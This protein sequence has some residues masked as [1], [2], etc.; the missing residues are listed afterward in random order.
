MNLKPKTLYDLTQAQKQINALL[1]LSQGEIDP[2]LESF[3]G[4]IDVETADKVQGYY[5]FITYAKMHVE[6][7][8]NEYKRLRRIADTFQR[9]VDLTLSSIKEHMQVLGL[10][11]AN[12]NDVRFKLASCRPRLSID[13][14][15]LPDEW[16]IAITT[17][18]PDRQRIEDAVLSGVEIPGAKLEGGF[19]LRSYSKKV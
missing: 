4:I 8:K 17:W 16:K 6:H 11:E 10:K 5:G 2:D 19:S 13:E 3:M 15:L 1:E 7:F 18:V 9:A 14:T 12:G